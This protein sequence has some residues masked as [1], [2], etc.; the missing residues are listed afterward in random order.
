MS[1]ELNVLGV[2]TTFFFSF[3]KIFLSTA[4]VNANNVSFADK[5]S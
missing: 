4:S 1:R 3:K 2:V 5:F